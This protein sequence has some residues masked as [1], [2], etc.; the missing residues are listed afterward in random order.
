MIYLAAYPD[1]T[2]G[3][4]DSGS[5][6][7]ALADAP[8]TGCI[9]WFP[10]QRIALQRTI[11]L[12]A[13]CTLWG[14][15]AYYPFPGQAATECTFPPGVT[16]VSV[17]GAGRAAIRGICFTGIRPG[18]I[19]PGIIVKATRVSIENCCFAQFSDDGIHFEGSTAAG[20]NCN[21]CRVDGTTVWG[22]GR[23]GLSIVGNNSNGGV[24]TVS[25][26][27]NGRYGVYEAGTSGNNY[28]FAHF[29]SNVVG[30]YFINSANASTLLV[31]VYTEN[32][33]PGILGPRTLSLGGY[34]GSG[35][36]VSATSGQHIA[37][38]PYGLQGVKL[39]SFT[40][41]GITKPTLTTATVGQFVQ[42]GSW[43][44]S[45]FGWVCTSVDAASHPTFWVQKVTAN[46]TP[47]SVD[48]G[49]WP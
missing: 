40:V 11:M 35:E 36:I 3:L 12:P 28:A 18:P 43:G 6:E 14:E 20:T 19:V 5:V 39:E 17:L 24:F 29:D 47:V 22:C 4:I 41:A 1:P 42:I 13:C 2:T 31:G 25:C 44:P 37:A 30:P 45:K 16:A 34:H 26:I 33:L 21:L 7:R 23:D 38:G 9:I 49:T 48:G 46:S 10:A 15:C 32:G 27:E 8:A